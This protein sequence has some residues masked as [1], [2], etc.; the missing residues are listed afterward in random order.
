MSDSSLPRRPLPENGTVFDPAT[1]ENF[2]L[3]PA[4]EPT[5]WYAPGRDR[6]RPGTGFDQSFWMALLNDGSRRYLNLHPA[7]PVTDSP[8]VP[9]PL[10]EF[11]ATVTRTAHERLH[12]RG[13]DFDFSVQD[14]VAEYWYYTDFDVVRTFRDTSS[15]LYVDFDGMPSPEPPTQVAHLFSGNSD[16]FMVHCCQFAHHIVANFNYEDDLLFSQDHYNAE[17]GVRVSDD[18]AARNR[19]ALW[20]ARVLLGNYYKRLLRFEVLEP[21]SRN[22]PDGSDLKWQHHLPELRE[23]DAAV[24]DACG[25]NH[26]WLRDFKRSMN[27]ELWNAAIT[28]VRDVEIAGQSYPQLRLPRIDRTDP[29]NWVPSAES[30][31]T[32]GGHRSALERGSPWRSAVRDFAAAVKRWDRDPR[33]RAR[34]EHG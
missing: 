12:S 24:C 3:D 9:G 6:T 31:A 17:P 28:D 34:P 30:V 13:L 8:F 22:I 21:D 18:N 1:F 32:F 33:A 15:V 29:D 11:L 23:I 14:I 16:A 7:V 2:I 25:A 4:P 27:V 5:Q 10:P 20:Y 19:V 26:F